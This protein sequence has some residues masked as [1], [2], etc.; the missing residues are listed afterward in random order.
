MCIAWVNIVMIYIQ[1]KP[2]P[3]LGLG[4]TSAAAGQPPGSLPTS[5]LE[6]Q[7]FLPRIRSVY[8]PSIVLLERNGPWAPAESD[9]NRMP[10]KALP[11][12][13]SQAEASIGILKL[14]LI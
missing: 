1:G 3:A 14:R 4:A 11:A 5:T 6:L 7:S 9:R 2:L 13:R 12:G 8:P 10:H